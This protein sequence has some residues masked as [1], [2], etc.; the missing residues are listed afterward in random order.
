[1]VY[2]CALKGLLYH[3][4]GAY[5]YTIVILGPLSGESPAI[6]GC[7]YNKNRTIHIGDFLEAPK[8]WGGR[9]GGLQERL[10]APNRNKQKRALGK[11]GRS[12]SLLGCGLL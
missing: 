12:L 7:P 3:D 5:V 8:Y 1:M 2:A 11:V 4:S 9:C 10:L 6:C